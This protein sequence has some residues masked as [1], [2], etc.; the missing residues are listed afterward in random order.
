MVD[1][2][3]MKFFIVFLTVLVSLSVM[4][5]SV[6]AI[7]I[8]NNFI[9]G[10][11]G[12][13]TTNRTYNASQVYNFQ[14]NISNVTKDTQPWAANFTI[15]NVSWVFAHQNATANTT[16]TFCG[17]ASNGSG[18]TNARNLSYAGNTSTGI[19]FINITQA[20]LGPAGNWNVTLTAWENFTAASSTANYSQWYSFY[21]PHR[22]L[23]LTLKLNGT[24]GDRNTSTTAYN[25]GSTASS[26][27]FNVTIN[28]SALNA[29]G[30]KIFALIDSNVSSWAISSAALTNRTVDDTG[31]AGNLNITT[32]PL[33]SNRT[34]G[35]TV[36]LSANLTGNLNFTASNVTLYFSA[37]DNAKPGVTITKPEAATYHESTA[38][39]KFTNTDNVAVDTCEY[40]VDAG[41]SKTGS[42]GSEISIADL[43]ND[44]HTIE[45]KCTDTSSND[46][47]AKVKFT[48]SVAPGAAPRVEAPVVSSPSETI[49]KI[50]IAKI[51]ANKE[52]AVAIEKGDVS[53]ISIA[54]ST[55]VTSV[56]VDINRLDA[57]PADVLDAPGKVFRYLDI[58]S[59]VLTENVITK[60]K[61]KFK[62]EK[63]W[64]TANGADANKIYLNRFAGGVW[65]RLNTTKVSEDANT[66]V[67]EAETPGFSIFAIAFEEA[68]P[69]IPSVGKPTTTTTTTPTPTT[70][71]PTTIPPPAPPVSLPII[72][73]IAVVVV[74]V[75]VALGLLKAGVI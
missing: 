35:V 11:N 46:A 42:A 67:Y 17:W 9:F 34:Y 52:T 58:K 74:I 3:Q 71:T 22:T 61:I 39:L 13:T 66:V 70:P 27:Q 63:S 65:N 10:V 51:L 49:S 21:I 33:L 5:T 72:P 60:V 25:F 4:S 62:A 37:R 2:P 41:S 19:Y 28:S 23:N 55:P 64:I 30:E 68:A 57:K 43:S 8:F 47:T 40:K 16:F 69:S 14:V 15:A 1:R 12:S 29:T 36:A 7:A 32:L 38:T 24:D 48:I 54:V 44:D 56:Y 18:C 59:Q 6:L 26:I 73:I 45:V 20:L 75:V 53:S 31:V 50:F